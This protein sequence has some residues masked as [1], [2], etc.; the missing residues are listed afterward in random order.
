[1]RLFFN[2]CLKI[3]TAM[4]C[5]CMQVM[6]VFILV[7]PCVYLCICV[8]IFAAFPNRAKL[9]FESARLALPFI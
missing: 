1:M 7:S 8:C 9:Q 3:K 6:A 5:C 4:A 2:A